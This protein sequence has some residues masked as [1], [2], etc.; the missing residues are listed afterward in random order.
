MADKILFISDRESFIIKS[1]MQK[2]SA[3]GIECVFSA[4]NMDEIKKYDNKLGELVY[5]YI[6]DISRFSDSDLVFL[7]DFCISN[8]LELIL[9]GYEIDIKHL[10]EN[11]FAGGVFKEYYRPINAN[12]MASEIITEAGSDAKK[13]RRKHILVVD[14]SGIMLTTI[15][16]WLSDKYRVSL[17]NSAMN[18]IT[19]L[20]TRTPDLILLD[21][22]MPACTG[23]QFLEM[24]RTDS[25]ND[26][27]VIFLT[28]HNEPETVKKVI[29]LRPVGYLLK[30]LPK[31]KIVSMIDTYFE[32]KM[33]GK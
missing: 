14:D 2:V 33:M 19:F 9:I 16:E 15:K 22:E 3:E 27:P 12:E 30:S 6:D 13:N 21:Y 1:I 29:A 7:R 4:L 24:L 32:G 17:V 20:S 31:E 11:I 28:G 26:I 5:L 8:G 10:K 23:A 25:G 18:A